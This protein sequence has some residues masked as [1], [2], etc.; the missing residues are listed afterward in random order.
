ME[1]DSAQ[2]DRNKLIEQ[3]MPLVGYQVAEMLR[4]VPSFVQR[5]D[6]ASAGALAL[7]QAAQSY[8][9]AQGV[10]FH[11]YAIF[12]I[13]GAMMDELR[14][15]D[16]ATRGARQRT[17]QLEEMTASLTQA[18]GRPP[19]KEELAQALGIDVEKVEAAMADAS[20]RV[21][22][23]DNT[24]NSEDEDA[25]TIELV[26]ESATPEDQVLGDERMVYLRAAVKALPQ[27]LRYVIEQA[28]FEER[29]IQDIAQEL[30]VTQSRV[31]QLRTEA[32]ALMRDGMNRHLDPENETVD[33]DASNIV[34]KRRESYFS[35]I[36]EKAQ[37][38]ISSGG[39][40]A[41]YLSDPMVPTGRDPRP[42]HDKPSL[43]EDS[44]RGARRSTPP[45]KTRTAPVGA[46]GGLAGAAGG[47]AG[48]KPK[49][50][51]TDPSAS[52]STAN[53]FLAGRSKGSAAAKAQLEAQAAEEEARR[54]EEERKS[55][56]Q[57]GPKAKAKKVEAQPV[58]E[59]PPTPPT[60]SYL[61]GLSMMRASQSRQ[62]RTT[63]TK[64]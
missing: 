17:K 57:F 9:E 16:W 28:F 14:S 56:D 61:G 1:Q 8:D 62:A 42:T 63:G 34:K 11:K 52:A 3:N 37:D 64:K 29:P 60:T 24:G 53:S 21:V 10:P 36:E 55:K 49:P 20:R 43:W 51:T 32:L 47:L 39:A 41:E 5:E 23:I 30:G 25:R 18:Q 15:M 22:S 13:R 58:Q 45:P 50:T 38:L 33:E 2:L 12:R 40:E 26:D 4:R 54:L 35:K 19:T 27:R 48:G 59:T 6:L 44:T 46:A 31:S 7:V